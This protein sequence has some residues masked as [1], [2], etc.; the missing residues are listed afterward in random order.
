MERQPE[1]GDGHAIRAIQK[2]QEITINYG[3]TGEREH[4]R[5]WLKERFKFDCACEVCSLRRGELRGSVA[6]RRKIRDLT[7]SIYRTLSLT[8]RAAIDIPTVRQECIDFL[9]LIEWEFA[10]DCVMRSEIFELAYNVAVLEGWQFYAEKQAQAAY[11]VL[12]VAQGADH[13]EAGE[14]LDTMSDPV[15]DPL[16]STCTINPNDPRN[17]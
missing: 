7:D 17:V 6:C 16:F 15:R 9:D 14:I 8:D 3:H 5:A 13:P 1:D 2:G 12:V 11:D 4:R 10:P